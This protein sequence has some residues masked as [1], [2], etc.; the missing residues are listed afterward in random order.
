MAV[1]VPAKSASIRSAL[2]SCQ[3]NFLFFALPCLWYE[4]PIY[5]KGNRFNVV[6]DG[7][8]VTIPR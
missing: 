7:A 4:R 2:R 5:Y 1:S 6:G 8:S 3:D